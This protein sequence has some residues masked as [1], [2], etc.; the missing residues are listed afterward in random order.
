MK[1]LVDVLV[2][3]NRSESPERLLELQHI[4]KM[5]DLSLRY[6]AALNGDDQG[7]FINKTTDRIEYMSRELSELM[8]EQLAEGSEL[9]SA[10]DSVTE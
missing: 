7:Y 10:Y 5:F 4:Q 3:V 8:A 6:F 2:A 1:I 9:Q